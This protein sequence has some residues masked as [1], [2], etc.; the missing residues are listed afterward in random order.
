MRSAFWSRASSCSSCSCSPARSPAAASS[1]DWNRSHSSRGG[2]LGRFAQGGEPAPQLRDAGVLR[3]VGGER[4]AVAGD[5]VERRRAELF[6]RKDRGLVLRVDV[7]QPLAQLAQAG[8]RYGYIVDE[9]AALARGG[10]DAR[11]G[12]LRGVVEVVLGEEGFQT[13]RCEVENS[14]DGAVARRIL[15]RGRIVLAAEQQAERTQQDRL[16]GTRLARDDVQ[17]GIEFH[18]QRVDQCVVFD[19]EAAQHR[20]VSFYWMNVVTVGDRFAAAYS[21]PSRRPCGDS[22]RMPL[23]RAGA[24]PHFVLRTPPRR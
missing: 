13:G 24:H 22:R 10:D 15:R 1:S 2:R 18:R 14:F 7:D 5:G 9:G 20:E 11:E 4:R 6:R 8:E 23:R 21:G 3:A 19:R 16:A 17:T 12:G